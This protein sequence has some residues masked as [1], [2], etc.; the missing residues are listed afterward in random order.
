VAAALSATNLYLTGRRE[1]RRWRR[2]ALVDAYQRFIELS[3][4]R[5]L[6]AVKGLRRRQGHDEL[7]LATLRG[8]EN[9]RHVEFDGLLARLRL[10]AEPGAIAAAETLHSLD[11]QLVSLGLASD[12]APSDEDV[13]SIAAQRDQNRVAKE[14]MIKAARTNLRLEGAAAIGWGRL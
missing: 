5:S 4:D 8:Q 7:D 12:D 13:N 10:I 3:F 14:A 9:E 2:D 1:E 11:N 6:L